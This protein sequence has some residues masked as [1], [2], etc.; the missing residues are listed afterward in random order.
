MLHLPHFLFVCAR[1]A[2]VS[3]AKKLHLF[4]IQNPSFTANPNGETLVLNS[5]FPS[6]QQVFAQTTLASKKVA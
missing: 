2:C 5:D 3:G 1:G 6:M 4:E